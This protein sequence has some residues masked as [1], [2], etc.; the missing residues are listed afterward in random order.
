MLRESLSLIAIHAEHVSRI[1]RVYLAALKGDA[2]AV[3]DARAE[4]DAWLPGVLREFSPFI[5]PLVAGPMWEA[6]ATAE[7]AVGKSAA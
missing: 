5:D 6:I 7:R 1:A 4:Y 3:K 2:Q